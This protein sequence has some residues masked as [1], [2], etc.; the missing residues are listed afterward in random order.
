MACCSVPVPEMLY[1]YI[2]LISP[3]VEHHK[4]RLLLWPHNLSLSMAPIAADQPTPGSGLEPCFDVGS[5]SITLNRMS[6]FYFLE[7]YVAQFALSLSDGIIIVCLLLV[8][9]GPGALG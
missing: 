9:Y 4:D 8:F 1:S 5:Q 7:Y 2:P 6:V 3:I